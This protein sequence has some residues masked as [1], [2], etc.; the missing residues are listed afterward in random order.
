MY[1]Q[2]MYA[3]GRGAEKLTVEES[4]EATAEVKKRLGYE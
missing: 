2:P 4:D 1:R 3:G